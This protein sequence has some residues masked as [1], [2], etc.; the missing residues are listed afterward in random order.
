MILKYFLLSMIFTAIMADIF[1]GKT[2]S[3]LRIFFLIILW[4][5]AVI[6]V[7][8]KAKFSFSGALIFLI[9]SCFLLVADLNGAAEKSAVW[10]YMFL[11]AGIIQE[12]EE[13][14]TG[15]SRQS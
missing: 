3:D 7:R 9:L 5:G 2:I 8:L 12:L 1:V 14:R 13:L 6:W 4:G 15:K 11:L 10:V